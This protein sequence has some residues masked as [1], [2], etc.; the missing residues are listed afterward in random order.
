MLATSPLSSL[1]VILTYLH[2]NLLQDAGRGGGDAWSPQPPA[3][4]HPQRDAAH[5]GGRHDDHRGAGPRTAAPAAAL[6]PRSVE[7]F[8]DKILEGLQKILMIC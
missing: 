8:D 6:T 5:R 7:I 3:R 2:L 4:T 1:Q